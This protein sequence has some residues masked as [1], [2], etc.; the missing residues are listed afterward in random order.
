M[1]LALGARL[2]NPPVIEPRT[3]WSYKW[4]TNVT[5]YKIV[6]KNFALPNKINVSVTFGTGYLSFLVTLFSLLKSTTNRLV[7]SFFLLV[8][9]VLEIASSTKSFFIIESSCRS[10]SP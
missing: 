6:V 1:A 7:P 3:A 8:I 4:S 10:N 5:G 9:L 2:W